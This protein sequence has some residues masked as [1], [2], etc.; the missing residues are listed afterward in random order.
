MQSEES[1][2]CAK[3]ESGATVEQT[4]EAIRR[5]IQYA[6]TVGYE[7]KSGVAMRIIYRNADGT[8]KRR[9][10]SPIKWVG[11]GESFK[12]MCLTTG[13]VRRFYVD[14]IVWAVHVKAFEV[15]V[16]MIMELLDEDGVVKAGSRDGETWDEYEST[17]EANG[18]ELDCDSGTAADDDAGGAA[19][20]PF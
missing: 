11:A 8:I 7:G 18:D 1:S 15:L 20:V 13:S 10:C 12:A 5:R 3:H 9:Y 6:L 4:T 2:V 17:G 14:R 16:P 19:D